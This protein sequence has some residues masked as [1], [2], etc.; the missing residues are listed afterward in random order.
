MDILG[1]KSRDVRGLFGV[2]RLTA[3]PH[4]ERTALSSFPDTSVDGD[5]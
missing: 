1:L 4:C 2:V 3:T 5:V